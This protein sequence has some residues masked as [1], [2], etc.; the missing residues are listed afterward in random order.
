[1]P[2]YFFA[3]AALVAFLTHSIVGGKY[4]V[5]PFFAATNIATTSRWLNYLR[6][7]ATVLLMVITATLACAAA[8]QIL[9]TPLFASQSWRSARWA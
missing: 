8:N 4:A 5:R 2:G 9:A 7:M 1:M 3:A 6:Y